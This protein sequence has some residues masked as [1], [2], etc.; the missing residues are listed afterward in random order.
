[1]RVVI[2]LADAMRADH[3]S[4]MGY[5]KETT[6][7]L[8]N[9]AING[10]LFKEAYSEFSYTGPSLGS[11]FTSRKVSGVINMV[12]LPDEKFTVLPEAVDSFIVT[13]CGLFQGV[14]TSREG[15]RRGFKKLNVA[16]YQDCTVLTT[17]LLEYI[18]ENTHGLFF[19]HFADTHLPYKSGNYREE[20]DIT[21]YPRVELPMWQTDYGVHKYCLRKF[22]YDFE[23]TD[24]MMAKLGFHMAQYDG[25]IKSIDSQVARIQE[26]LAPDDVIIF[27]ADHGE[28]FGEH[29]Y[30]CNHPEDTFYKEL[31]HVPLILYGGELISSAV[32]SEKVSLIDVA[33][34]VC[35]LLQVPIPATFEGKSLLSYCRQDITD[36]RVLS[37]L[38][39]LGYI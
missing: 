36:E 17:F 38:K 10:M 28:L 13:A 27:L 18:K 37:R 21:T 8:D 30:Y 22:K 24:C 4:C 34:T 31:L 12:T 29:D 33:P 5:D 6:P 9:M 25:A 16:C 39:E 1:M 35:E 26:Q 19:V 7:N 14:G 32:I 2:I 20:F 15:W 11:L 3:M 23:V